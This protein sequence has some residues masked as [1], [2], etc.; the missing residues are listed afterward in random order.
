MCDALSRNVPASFKTILCNCLSHGFRKFDD[1]K[2]FYPDPC[3]RV[4]E[5]IAK[6]YKHDEDSRGM[7]KQERLDYHQKN[8]TLIMSDLKAY[9]T[10]QLESRQVE[11]NDSL[12]KAMHY[13]L[14]HWHELSQFLRVAGAPLCRVGNWRAYHNDRFSSPRSSVGSRS[15]ARTFHVSSSR[16]AE[17]SVRVSRTTLT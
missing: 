16:H 7:T 5:L 13:M 12:G 14:K 17:R 2:K 4:I 15:G 11:P 9:I 10:N 6:V 1:L 3:I 8:S